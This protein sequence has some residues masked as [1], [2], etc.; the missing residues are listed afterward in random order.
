MWLDF[1][2]KYNSC[3]R[4]IFY[5][6][7]VALEQLLE[8]NHLLAKKNLPGY[9]HLIYYAT[10]HKRLDMIKLLLEKGAN[11]NSSYSREDK[12]SLFIAVENNNTEI[13]KFLLEKKANIDKGLNSGTVTPLRMA[14]LFGHRDMM[15]LLVKFGAN[16]QMK[17]EISGKYQFT[18]LK[19]S[20][21]ILEKLDV[22][23][24]MRE[25]PEKRVLLKKE[26]CM[27]ASK[28]LQLTK[29]FFK[30]WSPSRHFFYPPNSRKSIHTLL[31]C[32]HRT[33]HY[34]MKSKRK[35]KDFTKVLLP[36]EI[37]FLILS[38]YTN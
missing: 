8:E 10:H 15:K 25:T 12:T 38:M 17:E 26:S 4:A 30:Y 7:F 23:K 2:I 36:R 18:L 21:S 3:I 35:R 22:T 6:N 24:Y 1:K 27:I 33:K 34:V 28:T 13:V 37:W 9:F 29:L 32:T 5:G 11:V 19:D 31:L 20:K 16:T 14:C